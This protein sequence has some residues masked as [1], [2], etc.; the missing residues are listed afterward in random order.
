ME[1]RCYMTKHNYK[2][3]NEM[4][5]I[6]KEANKNGKR[7]LHNDHE[8]GSNEGVLTIVDMP[9]I[10]ETKLDKLKQK[11]HNN[12]ITGEEFLEYLKLKEIGS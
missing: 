1:R 11:L 12:S 5:K 10:K 8:I 2:N 9:K 6:S 7:V 3:K 4:L